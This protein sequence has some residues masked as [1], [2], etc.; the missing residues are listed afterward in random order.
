[1][2]GIAE[3]LCFCTGLGVGPA[4]HTVQQAGDIWYSQVILSSGKHLLRVSTS[5]FVLDT[6]SLR[7]TR[8]NSFANQIADRTC[9]G[10]FQLAA[11]EPPSWP[12]IRPTYDKQFVFRCR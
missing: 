4:P 2:S 12:K 10:H 11:A 9:R 7:E 8:L 5:D 1:M 3:V 6:D